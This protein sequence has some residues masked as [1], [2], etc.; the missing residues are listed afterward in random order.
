MAGEDRIWIGREASRRKAI[1]QILVD[2]VDVTAR[3]DPHLISV[4]IWKAK[5]PIIAQSRD[6][7]RTLD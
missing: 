4:T 1:C 5:A 3:P 2:G 7:P 6:H